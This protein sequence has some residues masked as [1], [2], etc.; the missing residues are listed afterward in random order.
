MAAL[1]VLKERPL[2]ARV[3]ARVR[4]RIAGRRHWFCSLIRAVYANASAADATGAPA[5]PPPAPLQG[6]HASWLNACG[7]WALRQT[8]PMFER[9]APGFGPLPRDAY[10]EFMKYASE[11]DLGAQEAPDFVKLVREAYLVPMGLMQRRGP[12]YVVAP[13]LDGHELVRF[14]APVLEHH[15][16]PGRVYECL[17]APVYGLVPDQIHLLLLILLIQ[18]EIDIVKGRHSYRDTYETLANPLQY[19]K[20]VPG[21]ALNL[22]QL[23]DLQILCEGFGIR[24]PKQWSVIAQKRAIEQLRQLGLEKGDHELQAFEHF[25][26]TIGSAPRFVEEAGEMISLPARF[27]RLLREAQL[28]RHLFGYPCLLECPNPDIASGVEALRQ[29]PV[30]IAQPE[31]LEAWLDRAQSLYTKYQ[32]WYKQE[33]ERFWKAVNGHRMGSWRIPGPARSRHLLLGNRV[34]ELEA[35]SSRARSQ[36]CPGL[37]NLEFQPLCRCG[38]EGKEAPVSEALKQLEDAANSLE[39]ELS[40]FFQQDRV[41]SKVQEWVDQGMEVN[42]RT[43]SYLEGKAAYPEI[44]NLSLFDQHLSGIELVEPVEPETLL[45]FLGERAWE[46]SALLKAL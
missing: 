46:K 24:I 4:E 28:F 15:P 22:N 2:P 26:F 1:C 35:L 12:E 6:S 42:S 25:L 18:G 19:D 5:A 37:G 40:L 20:I 30:S 33:H 29:Q 21:R 32:D 11:H 34:Q 17:S 31:A 14:L 8:Y 45:E 43:L 16:S 44:E 3:L 13:K 9:F 10:R 23:H 39:H 36:R 38:F 41:K 7:E 27:E